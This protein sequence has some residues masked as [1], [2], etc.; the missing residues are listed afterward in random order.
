MYIYVCLVPRQMLKTEAVGL[1]PRFSTSP[2]GPDKPCLIPIMT[3]WIQRHTLY[4][5][6]VNVML[7]SVFVSMLCAHGVWSSKPQ[8]SSS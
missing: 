7:E 2:E 8:S 4:G 6:N 5:E 1:R 3:H